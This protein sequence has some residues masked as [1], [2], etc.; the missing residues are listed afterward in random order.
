MIPFQGPKA[1]A[2]TQLTAH[3]YGVK[4]FYTVLIRLDAV[5]NLHHNHATY[6][7]CMAT[8]V[9]VLFLYLTETFVFRTV[10]FREAMFP[11]VTASLGVVWMW[12]Q[13]DFYLPSGE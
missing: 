13:R 3:I 8:F 5:Y 1:P 10:R 11:F 9:G 4:T 6:M 12:T 7:L 2:P